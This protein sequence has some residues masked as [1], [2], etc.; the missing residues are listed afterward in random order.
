M[1]TPAWAHRFAQDWIVAWNSRDLD[2][3]LT[4]YADDFTMASPY[5]RSIA[6]EASGTLTGKAA[7]RAYWASALVRMPHLHFELISCLTG[8][9][10]LILYYQ[11][12][13]GLSAEWLRFNSDGLVIEA[14]AHDATSVS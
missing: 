13:N 8:T 1:I 3:V 4:H 9:D 5:I 6:A 12:T 10:S 7:V 2:R 11:S 14:A